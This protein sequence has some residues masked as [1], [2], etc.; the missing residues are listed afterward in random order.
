M[1][2]FL[3]TSL[4]ILAFLAAA[5]YFWQKPAFPTKTEILAPSPGRGLF[6]D[7]APDGVTLSAEEA[8]SEAIANADRR[9]AEL[10]GRARSGEES[11]SGKPKPPVTIFS[12]TRC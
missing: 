6:I 8:D 9:R 3:I 7:G 11:A 2:T 10:L 5:V 12:T 4:V 1:V